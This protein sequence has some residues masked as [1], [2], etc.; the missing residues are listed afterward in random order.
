MHILNDRYVIDVYTK[1]KEC[2]QRQIS[3]EGICDC[4]GLEVIGTSG[5]RSLIARSPRDGAREEVC[6]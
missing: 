2:L 3:R 5:H 1:V 4:L 6:E